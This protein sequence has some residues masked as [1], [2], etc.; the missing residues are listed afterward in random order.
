MCV[1]MGSEEFG[2]LLL[3]HSELCCIENVAYSTPKKMFEIN[4]NSANFRLKKVERKCGRTLRNGV[5]FRA[6]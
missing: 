2:E 6:Q 5:R 4:G 3:C 1:G